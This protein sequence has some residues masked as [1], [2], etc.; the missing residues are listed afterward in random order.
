M[1]RCGSR[2]PLGGRRAPGSPRPTGGSGAGPGGCGGPVYRPTV[3]P[4]PLC[5]P[6]PALLAVGH[7]GHGHDELSVGGTYPGL[8][9]EA[10]PD[11]FRHVA[12]MGDLLRGDWGKEQF[13]L[14]DLE[15]AVAARRDPAARGGDRVAVSLKNLEEI[16]PFGSVERSIGLGDDEP[17]GHRAGGAS[18]CRASMGQVSFRGSSTKRSP[19]S[20]GPRTRRPTTIALSIGTGTGS[21]TSLVMSSVRSG[22]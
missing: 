2:G 21:P 10:G 18:P 20:D 7:V 11:D 9:G 15:P 1:W 3:E 17:D 4:H 8:A 14:D 6:T 12:E 5:L 16:L 13:S 19:T 22:S